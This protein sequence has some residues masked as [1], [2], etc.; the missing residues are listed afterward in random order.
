MAYVALLPS[1]VVYTDLLA[2]DA[3][4]ATF[5]LQMSA[6]DNPHFAGYNVLDSQVLASLNA[7]LQ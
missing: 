3:D 4:S 7:L 5:S 1:A 2:I 6:V